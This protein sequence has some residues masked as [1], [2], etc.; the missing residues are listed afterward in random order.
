[1]AT[2]PV[3]DELVSMPT[4][5]MTLN[6]VIPRE[7]SSIS[8]SPSSNMD[9]I[10]HEM[11]RHFSVHNNKIDGLVRTVESHNEFYRNLQAIVLIAILLQIIFQIY[12]SWI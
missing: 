1:M 11:V 8:N 5:I 10:S 12:K 6:Q 9:N 7:R 4:E 2:N 3:T